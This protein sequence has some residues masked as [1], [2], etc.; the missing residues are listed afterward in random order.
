MDKEGWFAP[1]GALGM[2]FKYQ[3]RGSSS[4]ACSFDWACG[5]VAARVQHSCCTKDVK[6]LSS[7]AHLPFR[8]LGVSP[9]L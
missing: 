9:A 2:H 5:Q 1:D 8:A 6:M 4:A 3:Q 7:V